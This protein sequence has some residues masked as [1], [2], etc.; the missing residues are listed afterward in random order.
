MKE[1]AMEGMKKRKYGLLAAILAAL[2]AFIIFLASQRLFGEYSFLISDLNAQYVHFIKLFLR[3]LFGGGTMDYTF[4][5]GMGTPAIPLYAFYCFSPFNFIYLV[6]GNVAAASAVVV[7]AKFAMA[8]YTFWRFEERILK[9][10]SAVS[11]IFAVCYALSGY[12]IAF[13]Y[14]ILYTDG[15]YMLPVIVMLV[16][17]YVRTGSWRKL[18]PA[19]AYQFIVMF[20]SGY[21]I[22]IFSFLIL[23]LTMIWEYGRDWKK[24]LAGLVK[25]VGIVVWAALIGAA[26]LLPTARYLLGNGI[27][28]AASFRELQLTLL[29]IYNNLFLGEMQSIDVIFPLIYSGLIVLFLVPVYFLQRRICRKEKILF[30]VPI[31]FLVFCSLWQPLYILMHGFNSPNYFGF[32]FSYFYSFFLLVIACRVWELSE[33]TRPWKYYALAVVNIILYYIVYMLQKGKL[34]EEM[35]SSSILGWEMNIIFLLLYAALLS[36]RKAGTKPRRSLQWILIVCV[37][38][39]L[40]LNGYLYNLRQGY[41]II[42]HKNILQLTEQLIQGGVEQIRQDIQVNGERTGFRIQCTDIITPG[43]SASYGYRGLGYFST[44]ENRRLRDVLFRLGYY[45]NTGLCVDYGGTA[46]TRMMFSQDYRIYFYL[47]Q[48][49]STALVERNEEC[50]SLGFMVPEE[51]KG[52]RIQGEDPFENQNLLLQSMTGEETACFLPYEGDI[53]LRSDN[54]IMAR[55]EGNSQYLIWIDNPELNQGSISFELGSAGNLP[56]YAY[57]SEDEGIRNDLSPRL[58]SGTKGAVGWLASDILSCPRVFALEKNDAGQYEAEIIMN[59]N[60]LNV[61][62]FN[63]YY[64]YYYDEA[65]LQEAYEIL[66]GRQMKITGVKGDTIEAVVT[67][68]ADAPVLFTSIP[69]DDGW[70]VR[71]DGER[72]EPFSVVDGAFL[73]L[74]LPPGEHMLVFTYDSMTDRIGRILSVIGILAYMLVSIRRERS[75]GTDR[76]SEKI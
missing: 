3:S 58:V 33:E 74:E 14:N 56:I 24:Y 70:K 1:K 54:M 32:R 21:I 57:F 68:D 47:Y 25:F 49:G 18:V 69:Y 43:Y 41:P 63:Q 37:S 34:S 31:V 64:F 10:D 50:L 26:V 59:E 61:Y 38:A 29:D 12:S 46:L 60:T 23:L 53:V 40:L 44:V 7:I 13:Y 72:I 5:V 36:W 65:R 76:K 11:A 20:Y 19:Y 15:I 66:A 9:R 16:I 17:G 6:I 48:Q 4:E 55:E 73:A 52:Y 39:E 28:S 62:H 75:D 27:D 67:A 35:Q 22:G 42:N 8:A 45:T 51:M 2:L 30:A 71:V